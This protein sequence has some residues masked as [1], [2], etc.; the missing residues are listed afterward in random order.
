MPSSVGAGQKNRPGH[1]PQDVQDHRVG[2]HAKAHTAIGHDRAA[3]PRRGPG[4]EEEE[5]ELEE[6]EDDD[7]DDELEENED[8]LDG[9][10]DEE[11]EEED[12]ED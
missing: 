11:L 1:H 10:E 8:D 4:D 2:G 6:D 5:D 7:L 9:D 3:N 12:D